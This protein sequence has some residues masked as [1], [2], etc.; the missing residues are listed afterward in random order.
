MNGQLGNGL[1]AAVDRIYPDAQAV[2]VGRTNYPELRLLELREQKGSTR[3]AVLHWA[4]CRHEA[5]VVESHL[6]EACMGRAKVTN[7]SAKSSG[8]WFGHWNCIYLVWH[9]RRGASESERTAFGRVEHLDRG[10]CI[11]PTRGFLREPI[12]LATD[13]SER[14]AIEERARYLDEDADFRAALAD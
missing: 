8:G 1:L 3:M 9:P 10:H 7:A 14:A 13:L 2:Y 6:I 5:A 4:S 11:V 12:Y